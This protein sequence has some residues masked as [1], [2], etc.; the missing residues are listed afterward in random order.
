MTVVNDGGMEVIV[1]E[2]EASDPAIKFFQKL[3]DRFPFTC[4]HFSDK[5]AGEN[6]V[7]FRNMTLY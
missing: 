1:V 6:T 5:E 2:N 7:L 3:P 4:H